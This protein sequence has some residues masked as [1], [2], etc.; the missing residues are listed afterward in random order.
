MLVA[1]IGGIDPFQIIV[2]D[3]TIGSVVS[4]VKDNGYFSG[5]GGGITID[6][7]SNT[8]FFAGTTPASYRLSI[9]QLDILPPSGNPGP[10]ATMQL[11]SYNFV[12]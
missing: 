9:M 11:S 4:K 1:F 5:L 3:A 6:P 8:I 7:V 12:A 10:F 2:I